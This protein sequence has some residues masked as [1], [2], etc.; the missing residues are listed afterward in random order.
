MDFYE[1]TTGHCLDVVYAS[2]VLYNNK[3]IYR[4][5]NTWMYTIPGTSYNTANTT[6]ECGHIKR[7]FKR[8]VGELGYNE[9]TIQR[10]YDAIAE[11]ETQFRT[12]EYPI[13]KAYPNL[14]HEREL[15]Y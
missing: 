3:K 9:D 8:Y 7:T 2:W 10:I 15:D 13:V 6:K 1:M 12:D 4:D 11:K 14:I 5:W